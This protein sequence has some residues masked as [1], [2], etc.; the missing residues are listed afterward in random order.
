MTVRS[1][2]IH[3]LSRRIT[4]YCRD[5]QQL[6][7]S[8]FSVRVFDSSKFAGAIGPVLLHALANVRKSIVA[9]RATVAMIPSTYTLL[10]FT[11]A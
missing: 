8:S 9:T 5:Q 10:L 6:E 11:R 2:A 1:S 3:S 7:A 4:P